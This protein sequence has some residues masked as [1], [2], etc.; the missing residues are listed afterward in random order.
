MDECY[1]S[2]IC[3]D[4]PICQPWVDVG[5][6]Q[7]AE[8]LGT[9]VAPAFALYAKEPME[10][11]PVCH[12][13]GQTDHTCRYTLKPCEVCGGSGGGP[14]GPGQPDAPT[15]QWC[16]GQGNLPVGIKEGA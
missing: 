1:P 5:A 11:C 14:S 10:D 6:P 8:A 9:N 3:G 4:C 7:G 12:G 15:C 13:Y 16:N 2:S